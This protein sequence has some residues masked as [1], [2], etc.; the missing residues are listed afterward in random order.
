NSCVQ[1]LGLQTY[2]C[3]APD[4][5]NL[6]VG[7]GPLPASGFVPGATVDACPQP[8]PGQDPAC[9]LPLGSTCPMDRL[10]CAYRSAFGAGSDAGCL[11]CGTHQYQVRCCLGVWTSG[12]RCPADAGTDAGMD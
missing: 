12:D 4:F 7:N 11:D 9:A 10:A 6:T 8:V 2:V 5:A 1:A 3:C